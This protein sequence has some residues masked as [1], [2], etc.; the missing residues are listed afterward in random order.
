M[1]RSTILTLGVASGA[2]LVATSVVASPPKTQAGWQPGRSGP[3]TVAPRVDPAAAARP[4]PRPEPGDRARWRWPLRPRPT[5]LRQFRAPASTYGAGHRGLDLAADDGAVV[6]AV[7][8]G[9]VTHAGV[10]AGRGTV[11]V[12][13]AGGLR[14]TYEPVDAVVTA[15]AVV[16]VGDVVGTFRARDGPAHCG[17][18][19][20]LHLGARRAGSYLDPYPLLAGGRLALLPLR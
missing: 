17:G 7:E 11:S 8:G 20:C 19:Q 13:H 16:S 14:S 15:G 1:F 4:T 18:R 10:V 9:V 2:L 3:V 5:V 6:L 12:E